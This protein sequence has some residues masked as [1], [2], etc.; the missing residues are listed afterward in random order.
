MSKKRF[1]IAIFS[2]S[3]QRGECCTV[4]SG[5]EAES[6][7]DELPDG[8]PDGLLGGLSADAVNVGAGAEEDPSAVD[9]VL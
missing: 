9:P 2:V 4:D 5:R 6:L 3:Y 1:A 7:S 8:L